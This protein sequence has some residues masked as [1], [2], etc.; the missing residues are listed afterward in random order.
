M[1]GGEPVS[2][3]PAERL[4]GC[5]EHALR[6]DVAHEGSLYLNLLACVYLGAP[7]RAEPELAQLFY[8]QAGAESVD[9]DTVLTA[10]LLGVPS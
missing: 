3:I 1:G 8:D 2:R 6:F 4:R 7:E 5:V 9:G 10:L